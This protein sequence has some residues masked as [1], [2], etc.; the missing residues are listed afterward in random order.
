MG[1]YESRG[2]LAKATKNL[3]A[4]WQYLK[5]QWDDPQAEQIEKETLEQL[6]KDVRSAGEAMDAIKLIVASARRDCGQNW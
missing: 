3:I 5:T 2:N 1:L 6:E 4:K